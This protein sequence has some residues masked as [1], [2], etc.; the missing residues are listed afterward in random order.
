LNRQT[1]EPG[2]QVTFRRLAPRDAAEV[3]YLELEIFRYPWSENSLRDCL[4]LATVEGEAA[5]IEGRIVGYLIIQ[6]LFDEAHILNLAVQQSHRGRGIARALL[7]RF[8]FTT[9]KRGITRTF[10]EVR[11][12][13]YAAQKLYFSLGF[14]PL[15]A[16]RNYYPDGEDALILVKKL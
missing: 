16:R 9:V 3:A 15:S 2:G 14:A 11:A 5:L 6:S 10:L 4:E 7:E 1:L 12:S 8:L 13:N